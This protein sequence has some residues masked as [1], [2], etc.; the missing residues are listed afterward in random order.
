MKQHSRVTALLFLVLYGVALRA[1]GAGSE[2]NQLF[3]LDEHSA[4]GLEIQCSPA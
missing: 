4:K 1:S 3:R 2:S